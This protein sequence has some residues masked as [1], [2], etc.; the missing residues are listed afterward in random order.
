MVHLF[1]MLLCLLLS[2]CLS[3]KEKEPQKEVSSAV[4][5][6][7]QDVMGAPVQLEALE[8][9]EISSETSTESLGEGAK[10]L[11]SPH[12]VATDSEPS[13]EA[14]LSPHLTEGIALLGAGIP[15][16]GLLSL[17]EDKPE[18]GAAVLDIAAGASG[19]WEE[20]E[21]FLKVE[22]MEAE[23]R[24]EDS[25]EREV[26]GSAVSLIRQGIEQARSHFINRFK[27][28]EERKGAEEF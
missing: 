19:F 5:S 10:S 14:F 13:S 15:S 7:G 21:S 26:G 28:Q 4:K 22:G 17:V 16:R 8:T 18:L 25:Q 6:A 23:A 20:G 12:R 9:D 3:K 2:S 1:S 27:A 24:G 11:L